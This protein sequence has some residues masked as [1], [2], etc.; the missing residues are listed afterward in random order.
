VADCSISC[1]QTRQHHPCEEHT[2]LGHVATLLKQG[3]THVWC[4]SDLPTADLAG[5]PL[6]L[7]ANSAASV[8]CCAHYLGL[9]WHIRFIH[10]A[11]QLDC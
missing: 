9:G 10:S 8:C 3:V 4:L 11:P 1:D 7:S 5:L 2:A 6:H